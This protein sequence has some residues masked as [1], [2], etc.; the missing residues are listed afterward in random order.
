MNS[1]CTIITN[2]YLPFAKAL[3]H[4][5][6]ALDP[7][8]ELQVLVVDG[9]ENLAVE[10]GMKLY[11]AQSIL[12]S[13]LAE[14][15]YRK[16]SAMDRDSLRWALKPVFLNYL[17]EKGFSK[18]IYVDP[19]IFFAGDF[20]FLWEELD[21]KHILLTPHW[22]EPTPET[23]QENFLMSFRIG[24]F[25]AGFI[26]VNKKGSPALQWWAEACMYAIY[27]NEDKAMYDDQRWLDMMPVLFPETGIIRHKGCNLGSWNIHTNKRIVRNEQVLINGEYPVIFIH[28]NHE[29]IKHILNGNDGALRPYFDEYQKLFGREDLG[30]Y[31]PKLNDWK[32]SNFFNQVKRKTKLRTRIKNWLFRLS[33]KL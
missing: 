18:L 15:I 12:S 28:F 3:H 30:N 25:N 17:L 29:T 9:P 23:D 13:P 16:Y 7:T 6:T 8:A 5:L 4:S 27:K 24:L 33:Q 26:G 14:K 11:N 2:D 19:D 10:P 1:F 21:S 32:N 31:V 20:S 22:T